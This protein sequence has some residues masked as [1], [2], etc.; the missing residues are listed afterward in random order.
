MA[1]SRHCSL[2]VLLLPVLLS[3]SHSY[4]P[5]FWQIAGDGGAGK[6]AAQG[7]H[8]A[9]PNPPPAADAS[10]KDAGRP[11]APDAANPPP[12]DP[13]RPEQDAGQPPPA[14]EYTPPP[15]PPT[16][17]FVVFGDTQFATENCTSGTSER[18]AVP[19]VIRDLAPTFVLETGDLMDHGYDD[20]AYA[21]YSSCEDP[22]L[23]VTPFFPTMGNH[24]AGSG[25]IWKYKAFLEQ[26]LFTTNATVYGAAYPQDF[27]IA[28]NDDPTEYSTD[29]NNP[30]HRD[31]VPS[32]V[33]FKTFY[34]FRHKNAAFV[35]FEVGTRYWSNTPKTWLE[36]KLSAFRSDPEVRHLFVYLHHPFYS[37]TMAES[38]DGECIL[39]VRQAY[40]PLLRRYDVTMA[41][42]GHAHVYEHFLVPDD[43]TATRARPSPQTYPSR[44]DAVHYVITGG[45]GGPL[46]N[47]CDPMPGERQEKS[48]DYSQGRG[49]S[50]HVTRVEVEGER[51]TVTVLK[52]E[53]GADSQTT[54]EMDRF[55]IE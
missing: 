8:D 22:F 42:S 53:G 48:Y 52:V 31:S 13:V 14:D 18:L 10:G 30:S 7:K 45:G 32:G 1:G 6:D 37:T 38:A 33:S 24:D 20:G 43:D 50:Y 17:S 16:F 44:T 15:P 19:R 40:E 35:S 46:P 54:S 2:F 29:F 21:K 39:P 47:G 9:D 3:C 26:Q 5:D 51:L 41:F 23:S 49:C 28:Y 25:G 55:V 27:L 12:A 11:P 4:G 36:Q 34:S